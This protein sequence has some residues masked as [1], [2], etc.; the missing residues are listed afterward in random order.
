[1]IGNGEAYANRNPDSRNTFYDT[2]IGEG[3]YKSVGDGRYHNGEP[4][5]C[6]F[7]KTGTTFSDDCFLDDVKNAEAALPYIAG[8]H[9]YVRK[10]LPQYAG[11]ISIKV[12]IPEVWSQSS[13]GW[14]KG[15]KFLV[16]PLVPNFQKFNSNSGAADTTAEV[17]QALSHYSYH[18]SD[19]RELLCDLQGGKIGNS[20]ILSDVVIMSADKKYGN[21]DLGLPGIENFCAEHECGRFCSREWKNWSNAK[22]RYQPVMSTTITLD[23][24]HV[25]TPHTNRQHVREFPC[26]ILFTQNSIKGQFQDG[27]TLLDT[28][29]E[30][31][32]QDIQKRDIPMITAVRYQG[33]LWTLDNRRLAVFRLLQ[34]ANK[35]HK[36]KVEVVSFD[37]VEDEF[38]RKWDG[39]NGH[40]IA[41]RQTNYVIGRS[42]S[43]TQY[44]GLAQIR[45]TYPSESST[46]AALSIFL[47]TLVDN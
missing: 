4:C 30:L 10:S 1:M 40:T 39:A 38:N 42:E 21:T 13:N 29:L 33:D 7:L 15:Q 19:G 47:G 12:N 43:S 24:A 17:A 18:V 26:D 8:F 32:R 44:P 34:M 23:V 25:P 37:R 22:R 45:N 16:E 9:E 2:T 35:L 6:K 46:D 3:K 11:S 31:A 36:I 14:G 27:R 28:A 5:V 20:Y 41:I